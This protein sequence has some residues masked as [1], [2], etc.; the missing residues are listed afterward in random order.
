MPLIQCSLGAVSP[1]VNGTTYSFERDRLGR[2]VALVQPD[3]DITMFLAVEHYTLVPENEPAPAPAP[4]QT[5]AVPTV[6]QQPG[7]QGGG[8]E[9]PPKTGSGKA[10]PKEVDLTDPSRISGIGPALKQRLAERNITTIAQIAE[11]DDAAAAKLDEEMGLNGR[12]GRDMWVD[13]AKQIIAADAPQ[14]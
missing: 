9:Q 1:T 3:R 14:Q 7:L 6:D 10:P 13:Q 12:I 8:A 2:Y 11:L 5:A 4:P